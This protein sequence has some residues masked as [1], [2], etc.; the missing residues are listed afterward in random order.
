[1]MSGSGEGEGSH[2]RCTGVKWERRYRRYFV[3]KYFIFL[4]FFI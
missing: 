2:V 3:S 1:M 4:L